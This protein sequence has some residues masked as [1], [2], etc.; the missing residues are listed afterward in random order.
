MLQKIRL[1]EKRSLFI[2]N[3][4]NLVKQDQRKEWIV[5]DL[6]KNIG[7]SNSIFNTLIKKGVLVFT[8][9]M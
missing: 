3:Y 2:Q 9:R 4:L 6:L 7:F 8:K 5:S 1:T